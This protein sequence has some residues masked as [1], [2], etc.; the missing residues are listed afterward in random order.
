VKERDSWGP[1][2]G[3]ADAWARVVERWTPPTLPGEA[4]ALLDAPGRVIAVEVRSPLDS[5]P[6]DRS[7]MDGYAVRAAD[8]AGVGEETREALTVV[9][10]VRMGQPAGTALEAGQAMWVATGSMLPPGSDA[11]VN[12]ERTETS[13]PAGEGVARVRVAG[14]VAVGDNVVYRGADLKRGDVVLRPGRRLRPQDVAVLA[15]LGQTEVEVVRRPRVAVL[16]TGDELR[17][18]GEALEPGQIYNSN[19]YALAAQVALAGGLPELWPPIPDDLDAVAGALRE[20]LA[21]AEVVLVSGGSSVG[22]KD[23]TVQALEVIPGT[24]VIVHGVATRPGRPS[25]LATAGDRLVVGIPGNPVSAI[26]S[27]EMFGR[28]ALQRLLR[29]SPEETAVPRGGARLVAR[30]EAPISSTRGRQDYAR[31]SLRAAE[32]GEAGVRWLASPVPG[33]SAILTSM[34]FA[35]GLVVVPPEAAQLRE[36]EEVEVTTF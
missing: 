33:T 35:D 24:E 9:G 14:A 31:V 28:P 25:I 23:L 15:S 10:E 3:P 7:A 11:V 36:G 17:A 29:L 26:I 1:L 30:L 18:P 6:F 19:A 34:V 32:P 27:F 12:V 8:L 16:V 22:I 2:P 13:T 21:R 20:A 4:V 5:P